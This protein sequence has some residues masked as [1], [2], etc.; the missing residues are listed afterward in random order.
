[1]SSDPG[2]VLDAMTSRLDGIQ[3]RL[4]TA[5]REAS[6]NAQLLAEVARK[7]GVLPPTMHEAPE[8]RD[9]P[10]HC[11]KCGALAGYYDEATDIVRSRRADHIVRMRLGVGGA[12]WL[13][14][15]GCAE[16][17]TVTYR[18]PDDLGTVEV[19]GGVVVLGADVLSELLSQALQ[20]RA[21]TVSL[22]LLDPSRR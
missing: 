21:H 22:R 9:H 13:T 5:D 14:C 11:P 19:V 18:A 2:R 12:I 6:A 1:M 15:R 3:R 10:V 4:D 17:V 8:N 20:D 16:E 7:L